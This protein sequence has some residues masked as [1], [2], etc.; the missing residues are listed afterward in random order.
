MIQIR[1]ARPEEVSKLQT[2]N[3]EVFIDNQ[4]Y[5]DDLDMS[6]AK[7]EKGESYFTRVVNNPDAVCLI[8]EE[9]G[10]EVGYIAAKPKDFGYRNSKYIEIENMGVIPGYRSQGIGS[11]LIEALL[12]WAKGNGFQKMYVNS[13]FK[14]DKAIK[15]Y[16]KNGFLEID[17]S[18]ERAL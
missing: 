13:Y 2:L 3:D 11:R 14:N 7:S 8:A 5:D 4:K 16:K 10:R 18:L 17:V 12:K 1:K 6:W 15:F 9:K